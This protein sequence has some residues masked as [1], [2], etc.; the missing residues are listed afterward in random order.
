M[1]LV[2]TGRTDYAE[3]YKVKKLNWGGKNRLWE[4]RDGRRDG[5]DFYEGV[6][7]SSLVCKNE[8]LSGF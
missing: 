7:S 1:R 2:N 3:I 4:G 8:E 6:D 5:V